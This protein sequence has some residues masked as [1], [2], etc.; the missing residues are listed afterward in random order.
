MTF[1][2]AMSVIDGLAYNYTKSAVEA[3]R[4]AQL[5]HQFTGD[6]EPSAPAI[7][8]QAV[9]RV[10]VEEEADDFVAESLS[11]TRTGTSCIS[12]KDFRELRHGHGFIQTPQHAGHRS[13]ISMIAGVLRDALLL[14]FH[15][16]NAERTSQ[17]N[18]RTHRS[19]F[20]Q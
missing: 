6:V 1:Q 15:D 5:A 3:L 18:R 8:D 7:I 10:P 11:P 4:Q 16:T 12:R 19:G 20:H 17:R 9:R 14:L 2:I 13:G